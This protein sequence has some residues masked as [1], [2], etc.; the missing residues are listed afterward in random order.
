MKLL[1]ASANQGKVREVKKIFKDLDLELYSLADF[2]DL[3]DIDLEET[4]STFHENS[5]QKAEFFGKKTGLQTFSDDSG[6]IVKALDGFPGIIS[7]RWLKGSDAERNIGILDKLHNIEDRS[8]AFVTTVCL[9][10]PINNEINY[11][12]GRVDG[13]IA[14][15]LRGSA[16]FGYDPIFIPEGYNQTFGEL[17]LKVKNKLS[18]R[19]RALEKLKKHLMRH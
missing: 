6:L 5:L 18:H 3:K 9:F 15:E 12:E 8:A 19:S 1:F 2:L 17:G 13:T 11:F 14:F 7:G 16:G 4:G 10:N